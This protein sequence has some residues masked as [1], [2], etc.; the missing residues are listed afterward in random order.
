MDK[1]FKLAEF[2]KCENIEKESDLS[3]I[4]L[5]SGNEDITLIL[6]EDF[7]GRKVVKK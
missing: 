7:D 6:G 4:A 5:E 2:I 1:Y 3:E